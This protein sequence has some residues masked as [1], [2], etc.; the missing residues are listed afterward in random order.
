MYR[1][2]PGRSNLK[3]ISDVVGHIQHAICICIGVS[4]SS[5]FNQGPRYCDTLLVDVSANGRAS[6]GTKEVSVER[7]DEF[8]C[9]EKSRTVVTV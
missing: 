2:R 5:S 9:E 8:A 1:V 4:A 6:S 7:R 3:S